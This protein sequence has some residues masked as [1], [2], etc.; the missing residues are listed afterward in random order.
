MYY[1]TYLRIDNNCVE[2]TVLV[3]VQEIRKFDRSQNNEKNMHTYPR[4]Y[5]PRQYRLHYIE[6][7][8]F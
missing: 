4:I 8:R 6:I 1:S 2:D 5:V 3:S 7:T